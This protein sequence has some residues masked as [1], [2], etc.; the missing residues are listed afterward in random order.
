MSPRS[1]ARCGFLFGLAA[2]LFAL[3]GQDGVR[4]QDKTKK[5]QVGKNGRIP[6]AELEAG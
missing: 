3:R 1:L 6:K 2:L 5:V 4:A